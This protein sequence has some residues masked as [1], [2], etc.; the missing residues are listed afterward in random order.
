MTLKIE[1]RSGKH[2]TWIR[3]SGEVRLECLDQLKDEIAR[4]G[5]RVALDLQEVNIVD[6]EAVRFLNGC[7]DRGI[8]VVRSA[9]YI[10]EWMLRE[11]I[12]G[13]KGRDP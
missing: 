12:D 9:A 3:L 1:R 5:S 7:Q 13:K 10:K 8:S 11:R 2:K 6:L 4:C